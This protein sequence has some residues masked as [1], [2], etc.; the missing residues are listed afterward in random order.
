MGYDF[1]A[2]MIEA[3]HR[4]AIS[5]L[6]IMARLTRFDAGTVRSLV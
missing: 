3:L 6:N 4:T 5:N 1:I 2:G